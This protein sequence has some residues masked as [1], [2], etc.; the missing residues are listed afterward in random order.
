MAPPAAGA[1]KPVRAAAVAL[2]AVRWDLRWV[3]CAVLAGVGESRIGSTR[4]SRR[5]E[6]HPARD[7]GTAVGGVMVGAVQ[8]TGDL[9]G[10]LPLRIR[11]TGGA[12]S[13]YRR[14]DQAGEVDG[15]GVD[16]REQP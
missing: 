8:A 16:G 13:P 2:K 11:V 9:G 14:G 6:H 15:F 12:V 7:S 1:G 4:G 3:K 10:E 5:V